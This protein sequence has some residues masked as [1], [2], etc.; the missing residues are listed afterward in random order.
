[1]E[2]EELANR[3]ERIHLSKEENSFF[4]VKQKSFKDED[5]HGKH[6][7]VGRVLSEKSVNSE[8]FRINMSQIWRLEGWVC[9]KE[10]GDHC[11]LIE[12]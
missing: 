5:R 2:D 12:F 9:F 11:F 8:A 4:H 6:C 10:L 1:M 7:I 3:W